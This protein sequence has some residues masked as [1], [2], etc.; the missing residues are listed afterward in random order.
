MAYENFIPTVWS[1]GIE[2]E[3]ER[4][5]VFVA[6]CNREYEGDVKD[7]GDSVRILG[8]GK[9]TITRTNDKN[10]KLNGAETVED[11]STTMNINQIAYFNYKI[12]DIDKRQAQGGVTEALNKETS[13]GL[14]DEM[15]KYVASFATDKLANK[16][17]NS[18]VLVNKDNILDE[19]DKALQKLYE[20]D[21]KTTTEITITLSP[22]AWMIFKKA[23]ISLDTNNS[24]MI[25][26]GKVAMYGNAEIKMSNNVAKSS[27]G[28]TDYIMVR[29]KRAV[30]FA[31]PLIHVE[32]YRPEDSFSDAVKGFALFD[33][34]IVRPKELFILNWK[35]A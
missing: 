10:F 20:K 17:S 30:A 27:N 25:K 15:D 35:Y 9:P 2:R 19:I 4:Q 34:K 6:D 7:Q 14:A 24:A 28:Q 31:N 21:V 3:L 22:R 32:P 1:E 18:D 16:Y 23:Y 26:N 12:D 33:G 29:T 8:V 13:E 5:H 11:T